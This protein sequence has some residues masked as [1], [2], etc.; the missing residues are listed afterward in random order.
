MKVTITNIVDDKTF[1]AKSVLFRKHPKY[2]KYV[3]THKSYLVDSAGKK[4]EVGQEVE[5]KP[6]KPISKRKR[7]SL[8]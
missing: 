6:S 8:A 4:V 7:W 5:I 1:R 2:E 3:T